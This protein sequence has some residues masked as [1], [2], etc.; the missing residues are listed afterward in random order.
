M[1]FNIAEEKERERL[2]T[3]FTEIQRARSRKDEEDLTGCG[4]LATVNVLVLAGFACQV[5]A[6][7]QSNPNEGR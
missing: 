5:R 3:G 4:G 2:Y 1:H 7:T 6:E